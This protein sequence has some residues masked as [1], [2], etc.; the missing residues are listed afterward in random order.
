MF[1]QR[2]LPL[3]SP[4]DQALNCLS[5]LKHLALLQLLPPLHSTHLDTD[6]LLV[7]LIRRKVAHS[8]CLLDPRVPHNGVLQVVAHNVEAGRAV[9]DNGCRALRDA[10]VDA[11]DFAGDLDGGVGLL[12]L[13]GIED[14]VDVLDAEQAVDGDLC[15]VLIS[16][17]SPPKSPRRI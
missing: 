1:H 5:T 6:H 9:L 17:A 14:L 8:L 16:L 2:T 7:A 15:D 11:V 10:G 3:P 13:C 4:S 12:V